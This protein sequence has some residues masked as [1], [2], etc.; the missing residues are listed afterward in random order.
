MIKK[1]N[2]F[3]YDKWLISTVS[4]WL[5]T[6]PSLF[7]VAEVLL[8]N[9][10]KQRSGVDQGRIIRNI[11]HIRISDASRFRNLSLMS[12]TWEPLVCSSHCRPQTWRSGDWGT[13]ALWRQTVAPRQSNIPTQG[14]WPSIAISW[15]D[16]WCCSSLCRNVSSSAGWSRVVLWGQ[17]CEEPI[18]P[19]PWAFLAPL[20]FPRGHHQGTLQA[21]LCIA[22]ETLEIAPWHPWSSW[23][24]HSYAYYVIADSS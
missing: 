15:G 7:L 2:I 17:A 12:V 6:C 18:V 9:V 19:R 10:S 24:V 23:N 22:P 11:P 13:E 20:A 3:G 14:K 21:H 5:W 1:N 16:G 8:F 4:Y